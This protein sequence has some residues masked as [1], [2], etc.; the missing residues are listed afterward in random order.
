MS[1]RWMTSVCLAV[2]LCA[3][4]ALADHHEEPGNLA[5]VTFWTAGDDGF[6]AGVA[7]HNEFHVAKNDPVAH[8]TW[9][10][11]TG[12]RAGTYART[13]FGHKWSDFDVDPDFAAADEA[14][15]AETLDPHIGSANPQIWQELTDLSRPGEGSGPKAMAHLI[16]FHVKPGLNGGFLRAIG[17][18]T[19]AAEKTN[20]PQ[21]W[22]WYQV[23]DGGRTPT[24][25]LVLPS[26]DWAGMAEP[27]P[28]F[29]EMITAAEGEEGMAKIMGLFADTIE[30]EW[31]E[32]SVLRTDL[33]YIPASDDGDM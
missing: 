32:T 31:A 9:Q 1:R 30:S 13:S 17:A 7:A 16:F 8:F 25:V 20:W 29:V 5:R 24:F 18:V 23:V 26:D 15:S 28:S 3:M 6:E 21:D 10:I 27:E 12:K 14:D 4:P 11:V 2:F 22:L 33:S 19:A